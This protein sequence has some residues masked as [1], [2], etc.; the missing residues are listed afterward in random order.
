MGRIQ[1]CGE[2]GVACPLK[3]K[4]KENNSKEEK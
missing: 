3:G 2:L 1:A 4:F